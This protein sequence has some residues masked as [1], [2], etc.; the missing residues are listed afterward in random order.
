[1]YKIHFRLPR[2]CSVCLLLKSESEYRASLSSDCQHSHR[3]VC[4]DCVYYN[5]VMLLGSCIGDPITCPELICTAKLSAEDVRHI[6]TYHDNMALLDKYDTYLTSAL[7][8]KMPEFIWCAYACGSGQLHPSLTPKVD[9]VVCNR[10]TCFFHHV[11]WH[12]GLTCEEYDIFGSSNEAITLKYLKTFA[13]QCPKCKVNIEKNKGCDHMTCTR[14]S[15]QFCWNCLAK[16]GSADSLYTC[17]HKA[18]CIYF[19]VAPVHHERPY[20]EFNYRPTLRHR[21][22]LRRRLRS[23]LCTII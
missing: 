18:T 21:L 20:Y 12:E 2:E 4:H 17:P 5:I 10:S 9:C 19:Q 13:K 22:R 6:L 15:T 3:T 8:E 7:L 23:A 16:F 11:P 1:L 14:C